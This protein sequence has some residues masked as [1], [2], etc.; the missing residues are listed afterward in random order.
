MYAE[1]PPVLKKRR[2]RSRTNGSSIDRGSNGM[3]RNS[4]I[5]ATDDKKRHDE[6]RK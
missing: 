3:Q 1:V 5:E 4:S 2:S 6:L